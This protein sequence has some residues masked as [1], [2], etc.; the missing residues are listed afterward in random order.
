MNGQRLNFKRK[1]TN[2]FKLVE[3]NKWH[4]IIE[5]ILNTTEGK[6]ELQFIGID[7]IYLAVQYRAPVNLLGFIF[8]LFERETGQQIT[9]DV[10]LL[11]KAL[12]HPLTSNEFY[13]CIDRQTRKWENNERINVATFLSERIR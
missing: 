5:F 2:I 11:R 12:Y 4:D 3:Q 10:A 7:F 8:D 6:G 13:V 9:L 1:T